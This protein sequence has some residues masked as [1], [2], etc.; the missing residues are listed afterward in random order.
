VFDAI[1]VRDRCTQDRNLSER[2]LH[3]VAH[4]SVTRLH[5]ARA[6]LLDLYEFPR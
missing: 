1:R 4:E 2:I 3:M 6:Q 5:A